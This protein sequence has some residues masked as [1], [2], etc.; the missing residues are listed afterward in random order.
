M[1]VLNFGGMGFCSNFSP[2]ILTVL[3]VKAEGKG[4]LVRRKR[5]IRIILKWILKNKLKRLE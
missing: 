1:R 5:R 4:P 2:Y 3:I